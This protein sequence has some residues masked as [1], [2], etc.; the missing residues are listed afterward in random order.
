M[1]ILVGTILTVSTVLLTFTG[2]ARKSGSAEILL[3]VFVLSTSYFIARITC[4]V[5]NGQDVLIALFATVLITTVVIVVSNM[6]TKFVEIYH[7]ISAAC[8]VFSIAFLI[9]FGVSG[10]KSLYGLL[11]SIFWFAFAFFLDMYLIIVV[12]NNILSFLMFVVQ[13]LVTCD[14]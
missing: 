1:N 13:N 2:Y 11:F 12:F 10:W 14:V 8:F 7:Y 9:I 4:N 3:F 6:C 5:K